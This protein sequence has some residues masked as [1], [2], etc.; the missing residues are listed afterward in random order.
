[1]KKL[2]LFF[3]GLALS[4]SCF[5]NAAFGGVVIVSEKAAYANSESVP[6][7]I[8]NETQRDIDV[9]VTMEVTD[10][11]GAWSSW[12][13][14]LEDG[15]LGAMPTKIGLKQGENKKF[16]FD[17]KK[18]KLPPLPRGVLPKYASSLVFRFRFVSYS[19]STAQKLGDGVSGSFV[20]NNPYAFK[21]SG[22]QHKP[23]IGDG[24]N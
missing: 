11:G 24:G 20:M 1:M 9:Y 23:Q 5:S 10:K 7:T 21:I 22:G 18:S 8:R 3:G 6:F 14:R 12:G 19:S 4:F 16:C 17:I 15:A 2:A 13:F